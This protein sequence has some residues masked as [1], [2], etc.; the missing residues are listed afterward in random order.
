LLV[1][2]AAA[3]GFAA[4]PAA[5]VDVTIPPGNALTV[6]ITVSADSTISYTWTSDG[7]LTFVLRDQA[8][9]T[10]K[11]WSGT[12]WTGL[13]TVESGGVY[14]LVWTNMNSIAVDIDYTVEATDIGAGFFEDLGDA[15]VLGLLIVLAVIVII[16]VLVVLVV[17][18]GKKK[19]PQPMVGTG[20]GV[21][22]P[23]GN[24][25]GVCGTPIDPSMAFC[26]K[27]GAKLR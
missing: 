20:A 7:T 14:T 13:Y 11:T 4:S 17:L 23:M 3:V 25:C 24:N 10:L 2:M 1:L 6:T 26:A 15:L 8:M 16:V 21:V 19:E 27:C 18:K 12:S 9:N 5:A 22:P